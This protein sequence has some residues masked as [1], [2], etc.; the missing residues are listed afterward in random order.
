MF[1]IADSGSTKTH[2]C[3]VS[4][5]QPAEAVTP[6]LNPRQTDRDTFLLT[7]PQARQALGLTD[8]PTHLYFYGAGCGTPE[9]CDHVRQ[10][11]STAFPATTLQVAGDLLGACRATCGHT[12]GRVGILGTGSN[13]CLYDGTAITRQ[14][15]STGYLLGDEGSGNHLGRRLLKDYLEER[16]PAHL[17]ERFHDTFPYR[18]E[19]F[20]D[21]IYRQPCPNR[22]LASLAPFAAQQRQETYIQTLLEECFSA[23]FAQLDLFADCRNLPLHLMGGLTADFADELRAAAARQGH[24]IASMTRDPMDGLL[25]YHS[26]LWLGEG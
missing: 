9:M 20:L 14:R 6:G 25:H 13:L 23:F 12:A 17:R 24:T 15:F 11:L 2:W 26:R 18:H 19:E 10:L 22:F 8:E 1:L 7:L 16:M 21:R 3:C 4:D 5:G